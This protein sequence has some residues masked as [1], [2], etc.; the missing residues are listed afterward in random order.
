MIG[1]RG[2]VFLLA[3][4]LQRWAY[5]PDAVGG[6]TSDLG[7]SYVTWFPSDGMPRTGVPPLLML[8]VDDLHVGR[9]VVTVLSLAQ[10]QRFCAMGLTLIDELATEA[11]L[12]VDDLPE[13]DVRSLRVMLG[14]ATRRLEGR[15]E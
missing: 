2:W 15:G 3:R 6:D 11:A 13:F 9:P 4:R 12:D 1:P 8:E 10:A 5:P 14:E 7:R